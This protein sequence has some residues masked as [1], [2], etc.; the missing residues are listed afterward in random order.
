MAETGRLQRRL[1]AVTLAAIAVLLLMHGVHGR[2]TADTAGVAIGLALVARGRALGR[3]LLLSRALLA[4]ACGVLAVLETRAGIGG[5]GWA[6]A[7]VAGTVLA[8]PA[9]APAPADPQTRSALLHLV[10]ST[11]DDPLAP[12][13]LRTDKAV[14]FAP[15]R[16]SAIAYR[17]RFG[18]AVV[19]GDPLGDQAQHPAAVGAFVDHAARHGWRLAVLGTSRPEL[20]RAHGL[21]SVPIGRDVVLDVSSFGMVGRQF[22]N[23]RQ[24]CARARNAAVTVSVCREVELTRREREELVGFAARTRGL[25]PRG[26]SMILDHPLDGT[27]SGAVIAVARDR[28]GVPVTMHRFATADG[29]REL[30]LDLPWRDRDAPNGVDE[31]ITVEVVAWARARGAAHVSLAFAAF[32]ELFCGGLRRHRDRVALFAVRRLDSFI[33]LE[34]LYRYLR[35]YHAFGRRRYVALSLREIFWVLPA[36]LS[37]EFGTAR[38]VTRGSAIWSRW[39]PQQ[40]R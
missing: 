18:T 13:A 31:L 36:A 37:L 16:A 11:P 28:W 29:G 1:V 40:T 33:N 17:V 26:F 2:R 14:V 21:K 3:P 23:V 12:F 24:A 34:R 19:S 15:G 39:V 9:P 27:H 32:P 5:V 4:L 7:V 20:W 22:R 30:S 38:S 10:D 35:K 8:L 25:T 6:N